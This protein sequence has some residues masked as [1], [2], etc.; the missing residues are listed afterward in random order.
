MRRTGE[1]QTR[2]V[3]QQKKGE[4]KPQSLALTTTSPIPAELL[5]R[6]AGTELLSCSPKAYL[7][8]SQWSL[9]VAP[10]GRRGISHHLVSERMKRQPERLTSPSEPTRFLPG[11]RG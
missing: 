11:K 1:Q 10:R 7:S 8:I 3:A 9:T 2:I 4:K 5:A 6:A